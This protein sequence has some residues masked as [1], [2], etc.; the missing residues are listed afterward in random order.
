MRMWGVKL[1]GLV[2]GLMLA[3]CGSEQQFNLAPAASS[4]GQPVMYNDKVDVL[5]VIDD[6]STMAPHQQSVGQQVSYFIDQ[7]IATKL[8]F[9]MAI[10]STDVGAYGGK[11]LGSPTVLTKNTPNLKQTFA[12]NILLP[13][14]SPVERGLLSMKDAFSPSNLAGQNSGFLRDGAVL[15]VIFLS[16]ED[17]QS[18]GAASDYTAFL[19][20][21]KPNFPSGAKA[22]VAHFIGSLSLSPECVS[23]GPDASV[24]TRYE[25]LTAY[26]QGINESICTLDLSKALTNIRKQVLELVT[27]FRLDREPVDGTIQ[28]WINGVEVPND[29]DNGWT[30]A[31]LVVTF[32]GASIPPADAQITVNFQPKGY[33]P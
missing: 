17:D 2:G 6:S 25:D 20:Q 27:Q 23:F 32:H 31:D 9:H 33:K 24:G 13:L 16:D 7:L 10:V 4:F 22:W 1:V 12:N 19:D 8:D 11:M 30:Y 21:L 14:G 26:S 5:W 15:V 29:P 3:A 18:A 28:V